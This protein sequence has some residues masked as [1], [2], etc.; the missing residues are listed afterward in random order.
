MI[1]FPR[2]LHRPVLCHRR[3]LMMMKMMILIGL[4]EIYRNSDQASAPVY[5]KPHIILSCP[6]APPPPPYSYCNIPPFLPCSVGNDKI[7]QHEEKRENWTLTFSIS[8]HFD[9]QKYGSRRKNLKSSRCMNAGQTE[10]SDQRYYV[11]R[12][13]RVAQELP[14]L[15]RKVSAKQSK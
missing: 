3:Y 10:L 4:N 9:R 2:I 7:N 8:T 1:F 14:E 6:V 5:K 13:F 11:A 12:N 15:P